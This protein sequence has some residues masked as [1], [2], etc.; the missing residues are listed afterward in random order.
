M[1]VNHSWAYWS[2]GLS[3]L[4]PELCNSITQRCRHCGL[5]RRII[6][7]ASGKW[8]QQ[9]RKPGE[10]WKRGHDG[11]LLFDHGGIPECTA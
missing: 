3:P 1:H 10:A 9:Y 5:K 4:G 11:S 7:L 2:G 6:S 8:M